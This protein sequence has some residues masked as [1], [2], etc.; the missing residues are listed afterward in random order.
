MPSPRTLTV[1]HADGSDV[2]TAGHLSKVDPRFAITRPIGEGPHKT[3]RITHRE[4]GAALPGHW[5]TV[6]QA[7]S[8]LRFCETEVLDVFDAM[9]WRD[10]LGQD[11]ELDEWRLT[12]AKGLWRTVV[13]RYGSWL[14]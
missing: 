7:E 9:A 13:D 11:V 6:R 10:L 4:S 2:Q 12:Y 14:R 8:V 3:W 5:D 1:H